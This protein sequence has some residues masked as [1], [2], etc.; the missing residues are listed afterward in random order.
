MLKKI[1]K[2]SASGFLVVFVLLTMSIAILG[3]DPDCHEKYPGCS[4]DPYNQCLSDAQKQFERCMS[5]YDDDWETWG[6]GYL[7]C[8]WERSRACP[9]EDYEGMIAL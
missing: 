3:H 6:I 8:E 4:W 7:M 1:S 9:P 5:W 2:K